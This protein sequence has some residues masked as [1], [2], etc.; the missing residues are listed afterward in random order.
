MV[1]QL[2]ISTSQQQVQS[3]L[4]KLSLEDNV[5]AYFSIFERVAEHKKLP[6]EQWVYLLAPFLLGK[7]QKAFFDLQLQDG[8]ECLK[9]RGEILATLKSCT[10]DWFV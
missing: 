2:S 1:A 6:E 3:A 4:W 10:H 7:F 8:R 5:K 9:L